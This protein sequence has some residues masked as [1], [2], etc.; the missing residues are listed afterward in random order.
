MKKTIDGLEHIDGTSQGSTYPV[1]IWH[2][3]GLVL[4]VRPIY[5]I[6]SNGNV[7]MAM[8]ARVQQFDENGKDVVPSLDDIWEFLRGAMF[9]VKSRYHMSGTMFASPVLKSTDDQKA[10]D[11]VGDTF[12]AVISKVN[13]A[14]KATKLK[15]EYLRKIAVDAYVAQVGPSEPAVVEIEDVPDVDDQLNPAFDFKDLLGKPGE[16]DT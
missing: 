6:A 4:A 2:K 12:V 3:S 10:A 9:Q 15:D 1:C 14:L 13:K 16:Q 11:K 7:I 5:Q 8:Y